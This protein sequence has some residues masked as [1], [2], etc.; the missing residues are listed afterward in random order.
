M[1]FDVNWSNSQIVKRK[2]AATM[3]NNSRR[4]ILTVFHH[5]LTSV[6][7]EKVSSFILC[8]LK[9]AV[10]R[11]FYT[12]S[13]LHFFFSPL[14][15]LFHTILRS[16]IVSHISNPAKPL[17]LILSGQVFRLVSMTGPN[18]ANIYSLSVPLSFPSKKT[19]FFFY[20]TASGD[21]LSIGLQLLT[22]QTLPF[23]PVL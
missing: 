15:M 11:H 6:T 21:D 2:F 17:P 5:L 18:I 3:S 20:P 16:V 22:K 10:R 1:C 7:V 9:K 4:F 19:F 14:S 8:G 12:F 23:D 13:V